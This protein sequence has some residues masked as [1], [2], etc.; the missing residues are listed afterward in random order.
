M[1]VALD[2]P[3]H[4]AGLDSIRFFAALWVAIAHGAAFPLRDTLIAIGFGEWLP[5]SLDYLAFN[6]KAAVIVFFVV[7]GFCIHLPQARGEKLVLPVYLVRRF[8]RVGLP[9]AVATA[10]YSAIG[11][12]VAFLGRFVLWTLYCEMLYYALYPLALV[13][14]RRVGLLVIVSLSYL[15]AATVVAIVDFEALTPRPFGFWDW[16]VCYPAWLLGCLLAARVDRDA[17]A[18]AGATIWAWRIGLWLLS[19]LAI[20][21]AHH[22]DFRIGYPISLPVFAIAATAW[23]DIEVRYYRRHRPS[24]LAEQGGQGAYSIYLMHPIVL[25]LVGATTGSLPP[26]VAWASKAVALLAGVWLFYWL[27]ERPSHRLARRA[28][29]R[30]RPSRVLAAAGGPDIEQK[31]NLR[32]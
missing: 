15:V 22:S 3:A 8:V 11:G 9:L 13:A 28:A 29:G 24:R 26:L 27:I 7:S 20:W 21:L 30:L 10:A 25:V 12:E 5:R 16:L 1:S 23:L 14:I 31:Q 6:G 18:I 32:V 4:Y 2:R 17:P 19:V